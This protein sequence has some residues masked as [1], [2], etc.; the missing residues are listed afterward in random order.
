MQFFRVSDAVNS[1]AA[2]F[3]APNPA[4]SH[5]YTCLCQEISLK[6]GTGS[7]YS[8]AE[9]RVPELIPVQPADDV[10]HKQAL[11]C[12]CFPPGLQLPPRSLRGL[13]P[14]CRLVNRGTMGLNSLPKAVTRQRRGSDSNPGLTAPESSTLTTRLPSHLVAAVYGTERVNSTPMLLFAYGFVCWRVCCRMYPS[15]AVRR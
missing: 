7:P 8:I 2:G 6:Q 3:L 5:D 9:R 4:P 12:H 14:I 10:S 1:F 15:S 11:G 13:L